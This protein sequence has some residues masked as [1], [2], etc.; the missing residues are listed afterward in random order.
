MTKNLNKVYLIGNLG[1]DP[2]VRYT[3]NQVRVANFN[4]ATNRNYKA[5]DEWQ[6]ETTWFKITAWGNL[7]SQCEKF[8]KGDMVCVEGRISDPYCWIKTDKAHGLNQITAENIVAMSAS[9]K[10][11]EHSFEEAQEIPF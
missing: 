10:Q 4:I 3:P 6:T 7:A 1:S 5:K 9:D 2:E 11:D 8:H